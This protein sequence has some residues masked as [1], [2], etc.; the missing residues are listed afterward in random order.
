M[1]GTRTTTGRSQ[2]AD[3]D[4]QARSVRLV[5]TAGA[6]RTRDQGMP[7]DLARPRFGE[8][9]RQGEQ[10]RPARQRPPGT[11]SAQAAIAGLDRQRAR[12]EERFDLVDA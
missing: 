7:I 6:E 1:G 2:A 8:R 11:A 3:L 4:S 10:H 5:G 9:A 12:G